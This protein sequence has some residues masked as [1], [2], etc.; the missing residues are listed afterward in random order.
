MDSDHR[1]LLQSTLPLFR[2]RN[3]SVRFSALL[4]V[5]CSGAATSH[6]FLWQ[7]VVAAAS[8]YF[9][10]APSTEATVAGRALT[11]VLHSPREI[12][13]IVL[14]NISTM[15]AV[16]P[17]RCSVPT[18]HGFLRGADLLHRDSL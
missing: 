15:A 9:Y 8:L 1:L 11:R 18:W 10:M 17:V 6:S 16:R 3:A 2:S 12:Q 5:F 14:S 4:R 7:V 13:Y